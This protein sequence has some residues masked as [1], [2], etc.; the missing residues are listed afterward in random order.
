MLKAS[1][2]NCFNK[3]MGMASIKWKPQSNT[4]CGI[5]NNDSSRIAGV[6]QS[7]WLCP[8]WWSVTRTTAEKSLWL[9]HFSDGH[10][11]VISARVP[12][13]FPLL[14]SLQ[15]ISADD[16]SEM[17]GQLCGA[18]VTANTSNYTEKIKTVFVAEKTVSS[19]ENDE[20]IL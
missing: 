17:C 2:E 18:D 6:Q 4:D 13:H 1:S 12:C 5:G 11:P 14:H 9:Y 20:S 15:S 19:A 16:F 3:A 8:V 7:T 10:N